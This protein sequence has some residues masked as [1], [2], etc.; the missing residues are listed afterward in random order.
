MLHT[1]DFPT[2]AVFA[3]PNASA[4]L[5]AAGTNNTAS[6]HTLTNDTVWT[7]AVD[8]VEGEP[9][10]VLIADGF[11]IPFTAHTGHV[12]ILDASA[13]PAV[14]R[15]Q[16]SEDKEGWFYHRAVL[17]DVDGD[18]RQDAI[19]ARATLPIPLPQYGSSELVWLEPPQSA[20]QNW[21]THVLF[22]GEGGPN[23]TGGP[24][25]EFTVAD[26]DGDGKVEIISAQYFTSKK[27]VIYACGAA[28]WSGCVGGASVTQV[29]VDD[30]EW[31]S[32]PGR[33]GV[34]EG[35]GFFSVAWADVN[36]DGR[37]DIVAT[38]N[39]YDGNGSLLVYE[40]PAAAQGWR[41]GKAWVRHVLA[42]GY[43][44]LTA[45]MGNG[46]PGFA[47]PFRARAGD[48]K[49]SILLGGDDSGILD[50]ITPVSDAASDWG[51]S[52]ERV[53]QST[54]TLGL[55]VVA[56]LDGSGAPEFVVPL[57]DESKVAIYTLDA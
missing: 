26:L 33:A 12:A 39:G 7:N 44:P 11:F 27:L 31:T 48:K 9:G 45:R 5:R 53:Y 29:V 52:R 20:G 4:L 28:R 15:E 2:D 24:D 13:W 38:T 40:Q 36:G 56:D 49:L 1:D 14:S 43:V 37:G 35:D 47:A 41:D 25:C 57:F 19:A 54:G 16:L 23:G 10:K 22:A 6:V 21:T 50:L 55:P 30:W 3:V 51:Y 8:G 34:G 17:L 32:P 42:D 18:G 46:A